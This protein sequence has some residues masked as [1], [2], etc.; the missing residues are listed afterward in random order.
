MAERPVFVPNE[1]GHQLVQEHSVT[2]TWNAGMAPSQKKKNVIAIHDSAAT[3]GVVPV[4]EVSTKSEEPLGLMLSAFNLKVE[5]I[6][7]WEIPL[8]SAFQ[9]GKVFEYGGPY[10]DLYGKDGY[11]LKRDDRLKNSGKLLKFSFDGLDWELEPKTAFYDWLYIQA[12]YRHEHVGERLC[13][14]MGFSDIEFNPK[15]SINCQ[16][17]SCALYAS[18]IKR[19]IL[20]DVVKDRR[21]FL[22]ILSHDSFYQSHSISQRQGEL[23]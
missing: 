13:E 23:F 11:A 8:E 16:A 21:L 14:Y 5:T 15:K 12:V 3:L 20:A 7:G 17:R 9:G 1:I 6:E 4:L 22:E 2:F 10:E 19:D 18:L